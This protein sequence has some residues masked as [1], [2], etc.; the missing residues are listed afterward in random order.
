MVS[1]F[2]Q[3]ERNIQKLFDVGQMVTLENQAYQVVKVGKPVCSQGEPKTD[4]YLLLESNSKK[5]EIKI[6]YKKENADFLENKIK[7]ERAEQLLGQDWQ[8]II[9]KSTQQLKLAFLSKPLIYKTSYKRTEAGSITL[10]WKF[11]LM[12]K[13]SGKLSGKILLTQEQYL[14]IYSGSNLSDDKR[15]ANVNNE[16]IPNSGVANYI[17]QGN[18]FSS[19][20]EVLDRIERLEDYIL[21]SPEIYFACKALNY[22]T[23]EQ[24]FDGDRALAVQ[25]DWNITNGKLT[26]TL[27]FDK[28]L[29]WN[30]NSV[31]EKLLNNLNQMQI[32]TTDDIDIN[33]AEVTCIHQ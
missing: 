30:G 14:D 23:F 22:R 18:Q 25:V 15:H 4:I 10:G 13:P 21:N 16:K 5:V 20:Q 3:A 2:G 9:E 26:P 33:N 27:V 8:S 11:E 12:N 28:P 19:A 17:L 7:P 6:S 24:K 29:Q 32:K 1:H 31:A